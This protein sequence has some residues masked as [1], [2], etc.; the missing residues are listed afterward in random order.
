VEL[1]FDRAKDVRLR[2]AA[3][4]LRGWAAD[5][6][7]E[8]AAR[9][10]LAEP[11]RVVRQAKE[12]L[13]AAVL[14]ARARRGEPRAIPRDVGERLARLKEKLSSPIRGDRAG[15]IPALLYLPVDPRRKRDLIVPLVVAMLEDGSGP[16]GNGPRRI[17]I[18]G[19]STRRPRLAK[20]DGTAT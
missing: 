3:Q 13:L 9:A 15:A 5:V 17:L 16:D 4:L 7:L 14:E 10:L 12:R 18:R 2:A 11:N 20:V 1:L 8:E 19:D 6:P